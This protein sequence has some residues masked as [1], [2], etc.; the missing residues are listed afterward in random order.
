VPVRTVSGCLFE[1]GKIGFAEEPLRTGDAPAADII[2]QGLAL[3]R[4]SL[5]FAALESGDFEKSKSP[6]SVQIP[7]YKKY[8]PLQAVCGILIAKRKTAV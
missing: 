2:P 3:L 7:I 1:Q 4:R 8:F 6:L 5:L